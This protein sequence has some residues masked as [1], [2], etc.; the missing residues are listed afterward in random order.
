LDLA[1]IQRRGATA[2]TWL[3]LG[4]AIAGLACRRTPPAPPRAE[5]AAKPAESAAAPAAAPPRGT[6]VA[7]LYGSDLDGAYETCSCPVH[8]MGGVARRAT[9][10]DRARAEA[11]AV[12]VVDAGNLLSPVRAASDARGASDKPPLRG[13]LERRARLLAAASGRMGTT[14]FT[15]GAQDL[16]LGVPLIRRLAKET[17]L[18]V[19]SANLRGADGALLFDADRVVTAAGLK[20]GVFGVTAAKGI[21]G[22]AGV[23][24]R[25]PVA[26]ARD[27]VASLRARGAAIV[28]ALLQVGTPAETRAL[29]AAVP[30]IDW[31]VAGG[32]GLRLDTAEPD[33]GA[34]MLGAMAEGKELGRLDLHVVGGS[35]AFAD[36]GER[37]ELETVLA[38][39][40][41]QL[42]D[43]DHRLGTIDPDSVRDYYETRRRQIEQAIARESAALTRL[44]REITGSWFEN[45]LIPL[46]AAT[47]DQN[48]VAVLVEAYNRES[49]RLA[50]AGRPV[51]VGTEPPGWRPGP[52]SATGPATYLG[53]AACG[54]CHA[55]ALAF[56]KTTK[57]A[58]AFGALARIGRSADPSCV[59]CHVTGYL[60]PGGFSLSAAAGRPTRADRA[61]ASEL[62]SRDP[63][64]GGGGPSQGPV[65]NV[66]CEACHGPG[67][68]HAQAADKTKGTARAVPETVCFGCHTADVTGGDFDYARFAAAIVGPGHGKP[69][70]PP[71]A[72]PRAPR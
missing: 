68:G 46:D 32:T 16:A 43:Y 29:L 20:V 23:E 72:Q 14:A 39:H 70:A 37:A 5:P 63:I 36:R 48:G 49:G 12:L 38:D 10:I 52:A 31:A 6:H 35:L 3:G 59:G 67:Q 19:V 25:D 58:G 1:S 33:G 13:E 9:Q 55:P 27:E 64:A 18:P 4:L 26:A 15:P 62:R 40:R 50:A 2:G 66:G 34:R 54:G 51:G 41:R 22:V 53:T 61:G 60:Q 69:P 71:A 47:P 65:V 11:D 17:H 28:V 44:P 56:W 7:L 24:A 8:P 57:H 45:R 42:A 30:G 21:A